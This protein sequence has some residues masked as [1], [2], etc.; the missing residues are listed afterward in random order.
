ML[1]IVVL[2]LW[3]LA[4]V[5]NLGFTENITKENYGLIWVALMAYLINDIVDTYL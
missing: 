2:I 1:K 4:G 3:G 5:I